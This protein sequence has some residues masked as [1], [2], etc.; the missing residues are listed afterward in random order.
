MANTQTLGT[1]PLPDGE[2]PEWWHRQAR[3]LALLDTWSAEEPET[4]AEAGT[5]IGPLIGDGAIR[6]ITVR[7]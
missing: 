3:A 4:T 1:R 2:K 6:L 7:P 5:F